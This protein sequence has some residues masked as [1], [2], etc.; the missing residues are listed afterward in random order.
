MQLCNIHFDLMSTVYFP[1]SKYR[2]TN[3]FLKE[4]S[5]TYC[6]VNVKMVQVG[7]KLCQNTRISGS[8]KLYLK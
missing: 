5:N 2:L 8:S 4:S 3:T 6:I 7:N 1:V